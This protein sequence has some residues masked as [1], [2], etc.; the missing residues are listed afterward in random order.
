[1]N[2]NRS[3]KLKD[4]V[5]K[6][7]V[8]VVNKGINYDE[9]ILTITDVNRPGLQL[10]GFYGYFDARRL[11][12]IGQAEHTYLEGFSSEERADRFDEL[13]KYSI[14]ALVISRN[15]EV[16]P[17]CLEMAKEHGR[18]LLRT[19]HTVVDFTS[20][21]IDY[22]NQ[23]LAPVITRH[24]VLMDVYGEGV[25]ILGDSGIGKSETAIELLKRGHRLVADDAV[26]I[27]RLGNRLVGTAPEVIRHY[28]EVRGVGVVDVQM[29]FGMGSVQH[30]TQ[31]DLVIQL[32]KWNDNTFYDRLGLE[33]QHTD[34]MGVLI[35]NM[36]IPVRA[37][38][39][40]A[41]IVELA[42]MN[43]RQ[44]NYGHNAAE[45]F[46]RQVDTHIDKLQGGTL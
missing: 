16:F 4:V 14:P 35:P 22:L 8:E 6:F 19:E 20:I 41:G 32:E 1:M 3:V 7:G 2:T 43:N 42:T 27:K 23:E 21:T 39:N 29:L 10:A 40:L 45:E 34:I 26:E 31:I 17:E 25:L 13:F 9:E 15:L 44:K 36:T 11:Q 37:G 28:I 18:T 33:T 24:G 12:I 46:V 5:E 38:R 30:E